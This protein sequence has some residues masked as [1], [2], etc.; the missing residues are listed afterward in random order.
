MFF[1]SLKLMSTKVLN[2]LVNI[3]TTLSGGEVSS[4]GTTTTIETSSGLSSSEI[5]D[6]IY[7]VGCVY[8]VNSGGSMP[9]LLFGGTWTMLDTFEITPSLGDAVTCTRWYRKV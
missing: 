4:G 9:C 2:K 6:L 1:F 3:C 7:P 8:T 5:C